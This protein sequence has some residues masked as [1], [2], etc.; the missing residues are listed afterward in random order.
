MYI[1]ILIKYMKLSLVSKN[2]DSVKCMVE[3]DDIYTCT[4]YTYV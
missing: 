4:V 3:R 2:S 1:Y